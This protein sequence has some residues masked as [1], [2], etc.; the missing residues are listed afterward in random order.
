MSPSSSSRAEQLLREAIELEAEE[1][2]L[3]A[4]GERAKM[5]YRVL[6]RIVQ[7]L[8]GFVS[9]AQS[10]FDELKSL[11]TEEVLAN[12]DEK[13]GYFAFSG[14]ERTVWIR[15]YWF[16]EQDEDALVIS[17]LKRWLAFD[18]LG[19]SQRD[20]TTL[21]E[22]ISA[23]HGVIVGCGKAGDGHTTTLGALLER[24]AQNGKRV[25]L[26]TE[27][28]DPGLKNVTRLDIEGEVLSEQIELLT[29]H[30]D[31][32]AWENLDTAEKVQAAFSL[33]HEGHLV[34]GLMPSLGVKGALSRCLM[35]GISRDDLRDHFLGGW[36][37]TLVLRANQQ[38][39]IGL[40]HC[41]GR[42]EAHRQILTQEE[43]DYQTFYEEELRA[44][45]RDAEEKIAA[46][47][48]TREDAEKITIT[49]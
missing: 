34:L 2:Y 49:F 29:G 39:R 37:Q 31:V 33:A 41:V 9:D 47:L 36:S 42:E 30:F 14:A 21:D 15:L 20:A 4:E 3:Q 5:R 32:F 38:E 23:P 43:A 18:D 22:L 28:S 26:L 35:G 24:L 17:I 11:P 7:K 13:L 46:G 45:W 6:G 25:V 27:L 1:I 44:L 10:L 12:E 19:L 40:F 48:I 8:E 16:R